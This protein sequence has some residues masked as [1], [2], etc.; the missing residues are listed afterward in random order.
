[1]MSFDHRSRLS[2]FAESARAFA[3]AISLASRS[4]AFRSPGIEKSSGRHPAYRK[5]PHIPIK[6]RS[7]NAA[8]HPFVAPRERR[9]G[10]PAEED[11]VVCPGMDGG[12]EAASPVAGC[13]ALSR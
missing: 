6:Q 2:A 10:F 8:L 1:M 7:P 13:S 5:S 11:F 9:G 12:G 3:W 4:P